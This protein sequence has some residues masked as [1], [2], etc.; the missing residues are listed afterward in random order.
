MN[1]RY[2]G[3]VA[4]QFFYFVR[5]QTVGTV[6]SALSAGSISVNDAPNIVTKEALSG[7]MAGMILG[8]FVGPISY[9]I[10][11]ISLHV[12]VVI[13]CTLPLVST[14]ASSLGACIPFLC[15][16]LGLDPSVI[17][18]PAMT[19]FVDV[20][21]LMAYFLIANQIFALFDIDL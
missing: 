1:L 5:G 8:S 10:M 7:L 18:A 9:Y 2:Y 16:F 6:L 15:V 19:S 3:K 13:F 20:S 14:I 4:L 21:G 11:G 17:A 12:S